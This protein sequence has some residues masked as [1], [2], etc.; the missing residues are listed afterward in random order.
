MALRTLRI[1]AIAFVFFPQPLGWGACS[2]YPTAYD[3][4]RLEYT[5][6]KI[7]AS[8]RIVLDFPNLAAHPSC[9]SRAIQ[10]G[11]LWELELEKTDP[12]S[13]KVYDLN[14]TLV[15]EFG[16]YGPMDLKVTANSASFRFFSSLTTKKVLDHRVVSVDLWNVAPLFP[17]PSLDIDDA[18]TRRQITGAFISRRP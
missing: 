14:Q 16:V 10:W 15:Q 6:E 1:L 13:V 2:D 18:G 12:V 3:L 4:K 17:L 11:T 8:L 5:M 9:R 7:G